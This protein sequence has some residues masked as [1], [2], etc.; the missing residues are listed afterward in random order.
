MARRPAHDDGKASLSG[1]DGDGRVLLHCH[2]GCP[3]HAPPACR[4]GRGAAGKAGRP[5][6]EG[7]LLDPSGGKG[8]L[9]RL[10]ARTRLPPPHPSAP[11]NPCPPPPRG[12][13][14]PPPPPAARV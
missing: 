6:P 2:A 10:A 12:N 5:A 13:H 1:K 14:P 9:R 11:R 7:H 3:T 8:W 4:R